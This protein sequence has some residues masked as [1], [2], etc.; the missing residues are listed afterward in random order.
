MQIIQRMIKMKER[1]A[2]NAMSPL[3]SFALVMAA[4]ANA[5]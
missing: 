4:R 5:D 2:P 3:A 1:S